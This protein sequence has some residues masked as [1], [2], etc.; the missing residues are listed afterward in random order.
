M[1]INDIIAT[2]SMRAY[3]TGVAE[4]RKQVKEELESLLEMEVR[5]LEQYGR[6]G[7]Y[8]IYKALYI[9]RKDNK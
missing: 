4:G 1:S 9:L 8:G 6:T 2:N 3:E 7:L 5:E